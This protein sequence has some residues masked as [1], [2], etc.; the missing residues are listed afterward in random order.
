MSQAKLDQLRAILPDVS[1]ETFE[2]LKAF[3]A[4][5]RDW[6]SRMN[7]ASAS[8]LDQLWQRHI[9]DSV[10]LARLAPMRGTWL[11]IGSGGGFPG[12][13]LAILMRNEG[14]SEKKGSHVHLIES[15]GKKSAFLR[16]ALLETGASGTVHAIRIESAAQLNLTPEFVT[17]RALAPLPDLLKLTFPWLRP[18]AKGL[19]HKGRRHRAEIAAAHGGWRFDLIEHR[20]RTDADS[21]ILEISNVSRGLWGKPRLRSTLPPH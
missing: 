21:V 1:R 19:F 7:L 6:N 4:L 16:A 15:I 20:S 8:S 5:F 11:D 17:A 9:L 2:R 18:G 12:I 14:G 13:V 10:Q 3:E